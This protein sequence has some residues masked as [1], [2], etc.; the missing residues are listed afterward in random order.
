M[1]K[2]GTQNMVK[3]GNREG[4]KEEIAKKEIGTSRVNCILFKMW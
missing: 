1:R 2:C 4:E 3:K